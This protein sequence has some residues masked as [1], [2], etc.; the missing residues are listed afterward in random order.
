MIAN[1]PTIDRTGHDQVRVPADLA[2][3]PRRVYQRRGR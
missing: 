1:A 2:A 3:V